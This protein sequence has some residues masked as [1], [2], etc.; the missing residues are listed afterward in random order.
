MA[1]RMFFLWLFMQ[2][3]P[4]PESNSEAGMEAAGSKR[5][6]KEI[7]GLVYGTYGDDD[8]SELEEDQ[9]GYKE[10]GVEN[11]R[12][13]EDEYSETEIPEANDVRV[14]SELEKRDPQELVISFSERLK[15]MIPE[16]ITI[17]PE[18]PGRC[19][20]HLQDKIQKLYEWKIKKGMDLN[21]IIQSKKAFKNPGFYE[22]L[23]QFCGIDEVGSNY[24]K[25]IDGPGTG[26]GILLVEGQETILQALARTMTP[27]C[28]IPPWTWHPEHSLECTRK[29]RFSKEL[30]PSTRIGFLSFH[31]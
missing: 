12:Q 14:L 25:D 23:I 27:R 3:D 18:P 30:P 8:S 20:N 1:K 15:N 4:D 6:A 24:P 17:P 11:S 13:L 2:M 7:C 21:Y 29:L 26:W 22:K 19:S 31:P 5:T 28:G 10:E 9:D 16:E